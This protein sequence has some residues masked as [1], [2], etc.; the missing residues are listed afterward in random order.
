MHFRFKPAEILALKASTAQLTGQQWVKVISLSK[1]RMFIQRDSDYVD[2]E[3][4]FGV[5]QPSWSI[6]VIGINW[7]AYLITSVR[8]KIE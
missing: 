1:I 6:S 4:I 8:L 3:S 5:F 7:Y 2:L